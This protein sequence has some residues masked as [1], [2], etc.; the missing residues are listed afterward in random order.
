M[1]YGPHSADYVNMQIDLLRQLARTR[2][3]RIRFRNTRT[4]AGDFGIYIYRPDQTRYVVCY[5]GYYNSSSEWLRFDNCVRQA[6]KFIERI[7]GGSF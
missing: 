1:N 3:L 7:S 6:R 4:H 2:C 5:D